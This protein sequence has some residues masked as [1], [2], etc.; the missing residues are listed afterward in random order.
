MSADLLAALSLVL[1]L[2]GLLLF[3]SPSAWKQAAANLI[4]QPDRRLR[5]FGAVMI[6]CGL[7]ALRLVRG[8]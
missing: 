5:L 8:G 2:E 3:A 7:I 6:I 4:E 1:V